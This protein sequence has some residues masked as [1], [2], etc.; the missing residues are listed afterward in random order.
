MFIHAST[1]QESRELA[2]D[3]HEVQAGNVTWLEFHEYIDV[4]IRSKIVAKHR[5]EQGESFD[6]V[7]P[8]K[9]RHGVSIDWNRARR[10]TGKGGRS[11]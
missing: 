7:T 5:A 11:V 6:V 8:A 2:L 9:C 4:A 10:R 1:L 3:G